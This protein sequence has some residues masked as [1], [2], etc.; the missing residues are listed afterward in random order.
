MAKVITG[1]VVKF[2]KERLEQI[3]GQ[4]VYITGS[5]Y[6]G[7]AT[8]ASDYDFYTQFPVDDFNHYNELVYALENE[9]FTQI[10]HAYDKYDNTKTNDLNVVAIFRCTNMDIQFVNNVEHKHVVQQ[11]LRESGLLNK[12]SKKD[13]KAAWNFG[14]RLLG[15]K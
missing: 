11:A 8:A 5:R 2:V 7:T 12:L 13:R 14:Y 3:L 9:G 6:F 4:P 15:L 10:P 1:S